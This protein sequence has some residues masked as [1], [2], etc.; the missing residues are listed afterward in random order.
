M[1]RKK[2]S[3]FLD[4]A[5]LKL[6]DV[7][8]GHSDTHNNDVKFHDDP[9][10]DGYSRYRGSP[11]FQIIIGTEKCQNYISANRMGINRIT[12]GVHEVNVKIVGGNLVLENPWIIEM[13]NVGVVSENKD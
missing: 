11:Y 4:A 7:Y 5:D 12:F 1:F 3:E 8:D 10:Q 13:L 6:T 9:Q 2:L